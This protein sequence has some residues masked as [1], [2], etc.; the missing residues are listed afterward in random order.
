MNPKMKSAI[1]KITLNDATFSNEVSIN[2]LLDNSGFEGFHLRAKDGVANTYEVIRPDGTVA[3]KLSEGERN[4][5]AFLYYYHLVKGSLNSEAVKDKIVVID[6]PVSSMDSGALFIVS[7]LVREMIEVCYNNTD[8]RSHKVDGD[9]IKQIFILTHNV[10]F[11]KE[12]T[13]HQAKRYHSVSFYMIRK[14]EN[15]SSVKLCVRQSQRV[16]TEQEN[17]NPIQNSYA[18]LWDEYKELK[19]A[20]TVKNV[21]RHILEYYFIQICGYEGNDLHKIVLEQNKL[22]FVDEVEGQKPNYDRY[23][24]ASSMLT[25]MNDGPA[26]ISDG[27]NYIDDGSDVEQCKK[28]FELIFTAMHQEQHYKMMMGIED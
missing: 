15:I 26:V 2:V 27:F 13:H 7:A 24:L 11:H 14:I 9:Y 4:F 8:Y 3:E 21:I 16:P 28:V 10:Y 5:I 17:Y 23:N 18:A 1:E 19:T 22:L 20:N 25:Y 6:D 12:I